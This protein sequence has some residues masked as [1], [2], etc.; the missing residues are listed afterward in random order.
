MS[1]YIV[2]DREQ[3]NVWKKMQ[4]MTEEEKESYIKELKN[5]NNI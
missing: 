1:D 4:Y 5:S 2:D 3:D